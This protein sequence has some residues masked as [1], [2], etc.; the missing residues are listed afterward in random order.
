MNKRLFFKLLC[1]CVLGGA[2]YSLWAKDVFIKSREKLFKQ[3]GK[4]ALA[5]VLFYHEDKEQSKDKE[6]KS[7]V[8]EWTQ[9]LS[10]VS[11]T[12]LYKETD[13]LFA[14]VNVAVGKTE[15]LHQEY[16]IKTLPAC[17]LFKDGAP[18]F[19]TRGVIVG[20]YGTCTRA[21][22]KKIIDAYFTQDMQRILKSKAIIRQRQLEQAQLNALYWGPYWAPYGAYG[23][24]PGDYGYGYPSGVGFGFSVGI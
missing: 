18:L 5:V 9:V 14:R 20:L 12:P 19:D 11:S 16:G 3:V 22:L 13:I 10:D 17:V 23:W 7:M 21:D 2:L 8:R 24:G 15:G 6:Y 1:V 4:T